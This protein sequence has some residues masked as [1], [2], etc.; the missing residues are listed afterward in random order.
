[1][2]ALLQPLNSIAHNLQPAFNTTQWLHLP[3]TENPVTLHLHHIGGQALS[4]SGPE[5]CETIPALVLGPVHALRH[6][7]QVSS[8]IIPQPSTLYHCDPNPRQREHQAAPQS[9]PGWM[10]IPALRTI[11]ASWKR[12]GLG[13]ELRYLLPRGGPQ[14][15]RA[16]DYPRCGARSGVQRHSRLAVRRLVAFA[17]IYRMCGWGFICRDNQEESKT[18]HLNACSKQILSVV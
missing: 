15:V 4:A 11:Y 17:R 10:A 3:H 16:S 18:N 6:S 12:T 9:A 7:D 5:C 1:M 2:L 14:C 8:G 13:P